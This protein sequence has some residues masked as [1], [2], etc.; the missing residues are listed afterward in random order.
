MI[1]TTYWRENSSWFCQSLLR[2][3]G[4]HVVLASMMRLRSRQRMTLLRL[5]HRLLQEE[6]LVR[7]LYQ[8]CV[9]CR[10][11]VSIIYES[12]S[13]RTSS[14]SRLL[15]S[16]LFR[17]LLHYWLFSNFARIRSKLHRFGHLVLNQSIFF[18][19]LQ[20]LITLQSCSIHLVILD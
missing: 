14:S 7:L 5:I 10:R 8:A 1:E 9:V 18:D 19:I 6:Y 11:L 17:N 4:C 13:S 20:I 3:Y 2:I 15:P 16:K 12:A